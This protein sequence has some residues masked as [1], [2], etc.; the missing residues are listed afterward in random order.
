MKA[1]HASLPRSE[2]RTATGDPLE[3]RPAHGLEGSLPLEIRVHG[4]GGQG[5]VTCAKLLATLYADLGLHVQSFGD[6]GMERTGAPVRAFTRVDAVP[7]TNRNKVYAP[8]HLLVLDPTLMGDEVIEGAPAGGLLLLNAPVP[9]AAV[10]DRYLHLRLAVVDATAIARRH[11]IGTSAV[12]IVNTTL[13]GAYARVVGL[14]WEAVQRT[15]ASHE[16]EDDLL[17][18]RE[19]FDAAVDRPASASAHPPARAAAPAAAVLALTD[20]VRDLPSPLQTGSW[21]TQLPRYASHPP[22][23]RVACPAGNDVAG[24][25]QALATGGVTAAANVLLRTQVLPSVCGRVCP[26]PCM[27]SCNRAS[28]DGAVHVRG[29]ERWIGDHAAVQVQRP[30]PAARRWRVAVVGGG[31]AG[32][33]AAFTF[34]RL[35]HAVSILEAEPR[36]GGVLRTGIPAYRL[37]EAAL[38]RDLGRLLALGVVARCGTRVARAELARLSAENDA[39]IVATGLARP[40]GLPLAEGPAVLEGVSQGLELLREVRA[41]RRPVLAG[42]VVVVG[43]GNTAV[44]CARTALR[45]GAGRVT[46]VYRRGRT[47][48]PA[49]P[50]EVAEALGEGV[51]L[52]PLRQPVRLVGNERVAGLELAEMLLGPPDESG[53]PRP[54]SGPGREL[55]ACD[56]VLLALGQSADRSLLPETP[57]GKVWLSGDLATSAGTVSHAIGHG[58]R[59]AE[60]VLARL[61]GRPVPAAAPPEEVVA[62]AHVR[63]SHFAP[64]RA[65]R[66]QILPAEP[67]R[68]SFEEVNGGLR[69]TQEARRCFSC[70]TCTTC[71]TCLFACPE[72]II[73]RREDG[74][75]YLIDERYCK[76]C[77][78]CVAEC[79]RRAM[80]IAPD[81]R[82]SA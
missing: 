76:G 18:A 20:H 62:P 14:E 65:H 30:A 1:R 67:R 43:G 78:M 70:G 7:I 3:G 53:R 63:F 12:V 49:I 66:E 29:L 64:S 8:R 69:G 47:E 56:R 6:Y 2:R 51:A 72:G 82:L 59:V 28:Y 41:G 22:P 48:M 10:S 58:R 46:I 71:D 32:L 13:I 37:P 19:A 40:A 80:E 45:C 11:G 24:F 25:I 26:A 21:R 52:L 27:E 39:V 33:S 5:G 16:L 54:I 31:P 55:L 15:F 23:C 36:L 42:H 34:A 44:D 73:R 74:A 17:A 4:R 61:E 38:D 81:G 60:E 9:L 68:T 57:D 75:G 50:G 79:P 77:G 35:G